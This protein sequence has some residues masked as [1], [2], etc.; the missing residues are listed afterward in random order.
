MINSATRQS[1]IELIHEAVNAG[2]RRE[3]A[4]GLLDLPVRTF[5]RWEQRL[6]DNQLKD[7]RKSAAAGRRPANKLSEAERKKIVDICNQPKYK[8]LPP[9]QIV[10]SLADE[11][12]Y[13]ASESSFY[14]VL[15]QADQV[16][17]RGRAEQPKVVKKPK[18]Y[19]ATD[20]NQVWSW[21]ITYLAA[22][23]RGLFYRLYLVEDIFS[24]KIVGW[25]VHE[26]ET[27]EHASVLIRKT[28]L[29]E[30]IHEDGLVLHS[31]NGSPM[32]GATMLAALQK[33]GIVPSL[34]RP[35]VSDD[36]PYSESLFR[37]LKYMPAY[38]AKPFDSI[39]A[40]QQWVHWFVQ[41]YNAEHHHSGIRFVTP[42]QRHEGLDTA[43]LVN[44]KKVYET[45]KESNPSRWSGNTR[46]WKPVAEVWLN[47][48]KE[49]RAEQPLLTEVA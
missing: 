5:R 40:A 19:K 36:N 32:K 39:E 16:H 47:P 29:A 10:P 43:I 46:N 7:Q 12:V 14:R 4:C 30:G 23:V 45:A 8:S 2:A 17:R 18:G 9:T 31:D 1:A 24:R 3:K 6:K 26:D 22:S 34:S 25:E 13:L 49:V 15:R 21:D 20:A 27:A 41:W 37:T 44:R 11:G 28:C 42:N 33:L 48:P 35:S 38:P